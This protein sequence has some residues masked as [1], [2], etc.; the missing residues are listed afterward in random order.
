MEISVTQALNGCICSEKVA[1]W[2]RV[3]LP[4]WNRPWV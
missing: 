2:A 3:T 4:I 1:W